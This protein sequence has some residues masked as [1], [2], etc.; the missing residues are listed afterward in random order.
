MESA[1]EAFL[2]KHKEQ[3]RRSRTYWKIKSM[4]FN[5]KSMKFVEHLVNAYHPEHIIKP[6]EKMKENDRLVCSL[7]GK[8]LSLH[9]KINRAYTGKDTDTYLDMRCINELMEWRKELDDYI[10]ELTLRKPK[11]IEQQ[12]PNDFSVKLREALKN[13]K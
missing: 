6:M 8:K 9:K 7:C 11:T 3:N 1:F 2:R 4:F 5:K 10:W 12:L 13:K